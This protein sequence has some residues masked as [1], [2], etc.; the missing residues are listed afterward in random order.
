MDAL[1]AGG[2]APRRSG[3]SWSARCPGHNDHVASLS[4][5]EGDGGRA[6][7]FCHAGC[8]YQDISAALGLVN[9][10]RPMQT[11]PGSDAER[12]EHV[13]RDVE[14]DPIARKVRL[15]RGGMTAK[16]SSGR[17]ALW[18]EYPHAGQWL[19]PAK[20]PPGAPHEPPRVLY[21]LPEVL[22]AIRERRPVNV[23]EGEKCA[24][25]MAVLGL[26]ATTNPA[27]ASS[28][29]EL[30]HHGEILDPDSGDTYRLKITLLDSGK[31]LDVRG[32]VGIALFGRSQ[33]WLRES[34]QTK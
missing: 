14:G 18:W 26:T 2:F 13:Y 27:G 10:A 22:A 19:T 11:A 12:L 8:S 1:E 17:K 24:D 20:L 15:L 6:L 32:F 7:L 31:K 9:G 5:S 25:A 21:R 23:C 4:V 34:N 29:G 33:I 3:A 30:Y 16:L 28:K